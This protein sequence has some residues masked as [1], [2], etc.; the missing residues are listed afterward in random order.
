MD[1]MQLPL[2]PAARKCLEETLGVPLAF[3]KALQDLGFVLAGGA[4]A[5]LVEV[6]NGLP[7]SCEPQDVDFFYKG[8]TL[9]GDPSGG[10]TE[11]YF[12]EQKLK[13][14]L[15]EFH[16]V[17][18]SRLGGHLAQFCIPSSGYPFAK[19]AVVLP[20]PKQKVPSGVKLSSKIQV[21]LAADRFTVRYGSQQHLLRRLL[22]SGR[23]E[24]E[25]I[26]TP[27]DL[28]VSY[29]EEIRHRKLVVSEEPVW[30]AFDFTAVCAE[31]DGEVLQYSPE[32]LEDRTHRRLRYYNQAIEPLHTL[33]RI[34]TYR[35]KG[36]SFDLEGLRQFV[37]LGR[38]LTE[39][40]LVEAKQRLL[41]YQET[42]LPANDY[43]GFLDP[44]RQV[45]IHL[46]GSSMDA[47]SII[48]S[49][50]KQEWLQQTMK[51]CR[52]SAV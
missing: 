31:L 45:E 19:P 21:I 48:T 44:L 29:L 20:G 15:L 39:E 22:D 6:A 9:A 2:N 49:S 14:V 37:S 8:I 35:A 11:A 33:H 36:F 34:A 5:V 13:K 17:S 51:Y 38:P 43:L 47:T 4:A 46:R 12:L 30:S 10:A 23:L 40:E 24:D 18:Y 25:Q 32:L 28:G 16:A 3:V 1:R 41:G 42:G 50:I 26:A 52:L 7:P 27:L